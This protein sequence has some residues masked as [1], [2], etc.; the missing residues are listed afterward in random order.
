MHF[1]RHMRITVECEAGLGVSEFLCQRLFIHADGNRMCGVGMAQTVERD[2]GKPRFLD[3]S[4][5]GTVYSLT[6][7]HPFDLLSAFA[8]SNVSSL[9]CR[10]KRVCLFS[11]KASFFASDACK[12]P[13]NTGFFALQAPE[14]VFMRFLTHTCAWFSFR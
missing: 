9:I 7:L 1:F 3:D 6:L 12:K 5:E 13:A 10:E 8:V 2:V 11:I 4:L 14:F